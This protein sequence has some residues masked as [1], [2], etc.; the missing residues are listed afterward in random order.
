MYVTDSRIN[1]AIDFMIVIKKIIFYVY[2]YIS[3]PTY[4]MSKLPPDLSQRP[5]MEAIERNRR[6][7]EKK[8]QQTKAIVEATPMKKR[9]K[10]GR[11][12]GSKRTSKRKTGT[13]SKTRSKKTRGRRRKR[14]R[15]KMTTL[16]GFNI[17]KRRCYTKGRK[18]RTKKS[19]KKK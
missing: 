11:K 9:R 12:K 7:R 19:K 16:C 8:A 15:P 3:S 6:Y 5:K 18:R 1:F 13:R 17:V 14:G 10:R 4:T 2:I